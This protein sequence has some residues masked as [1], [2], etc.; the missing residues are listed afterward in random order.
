MKVLDL[1]AKL[2]ILRWGARA[3]VYRSGAER[4][5]EFIDDSVFDADRDYM[6]RH[7][8]TAKKPPEKRG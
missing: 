3:A 4:P 1:L 2:G 7:G 6:R 5:A 8:D